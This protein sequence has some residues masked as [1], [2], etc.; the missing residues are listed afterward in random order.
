MKIKQITV[1]IF[2]WLFFIGITAIAGQVIKTKSGMSELTIVDYDSFLTTIK[3]SSKIDFANV[4]VTFDD[5]TG[6]S[7]TVKEL[8]DIIKERP[9]K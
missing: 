4:K 3:I 1:F 2:V 7:I 9:I 5:L 6:Q 8:R